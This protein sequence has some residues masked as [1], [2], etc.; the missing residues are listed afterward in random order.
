[1]PRFNLLL[2]SND[3]VLQA[4]TYTRA[5]SRGTYVTAR[6]RGTYML[7]AYSKP[8]TA[9]IPPIFHSG[10]ESKGNRRTQRTYRAN[11]TAASMPLNMD[12]YV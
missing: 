2:R 10:R 6:T 3:T 7:S 4:D 1:M 5:R 8:T 12:S 9:V 11:K